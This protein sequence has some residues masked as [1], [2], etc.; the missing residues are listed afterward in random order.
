MLFHKHLRKR[1]FVTFQLKIAGLSSSTALK[2]SSLAEGLTFKL[3]AQLWMSQNKRQPPF[4]KDV[5]NVGTAAGYLFT[6]G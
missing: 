1:S 5:V 2:G 4:L 3:T 6:W